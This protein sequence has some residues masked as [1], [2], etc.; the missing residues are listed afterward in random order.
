MST[1]V[2]DHPSIAEQSDK[3]QG[4]IHMPPHHPWRH[5]LRHFLEMSGIMV[6]GM[7]VAAVIFMY[8]INLTIGR[9]TW[10]EALI[11]Y[12]VQSLLVV[13]IGMSLPMLPWMRFRGHGWRSSYE[14]AAAMAL[15][16]IPFVCLALFDVV[17]GAQCG[18]YCASGFVAML[19][20]MFNRRG[21]YGGVSAPMQ[22]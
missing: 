4:P 14:M 13:A 3:G 2:R 22:T 10:E 19:V 8:I 17:K 16:V 20:V 11:R 18:L 5:F 9:T 6:V 15:P 12:P 7:L 1:A 21:E